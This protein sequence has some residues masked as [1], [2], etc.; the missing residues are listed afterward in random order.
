M[1]IPEKVK[2]EAKGPNVLDISSDSDQEMAVADA[3]PS[4]NV[5]N[6][7]SAIDSDSNDEVVR[8]IPVFLS[9][10]LA[11]QMQLIQY[12]LQQRAHPAAPE[13]V[14]VK[15]RHC[16]MEQ[17]H[18]TPDNIGFNGLYHMPS[19]TFSSH[20]IPV[21]TNMALGKLVGSDSGDGASLHLVP[22]SRI[23]QMR[24]SFS[25]I[26]EAM[27]ASTATTEEELRRQEQKTA[28]PL[29]GR[30]SIGFQKKESERQEMARKSSYGYKKASEDAE[31]WHSLEVYDEASLQA[32]LIL[33]RVACPIE[34]RETYLLDVERLKVESKCTNI[35]GT[36][37]NAKY[38]N[39]LNYLPPRKDFG[40]SGSS[41]PATKTPGG[42]TETSGTDELTLPQIVAKLVPLMRQG[43]PVP[44]SLLRAEFPPETATDDQLFV[45]L[46]SCAVLVRG[47]WCLGSK[48]LGYSPPMTRTRTFLMCLFQTMGVVHKERLLGVFAEDDGDASEGGVTPEVVDFLL[49][50]L[51]EKS[52]AGWVLKVADDA[53]FQKL[54]PQ[55]TMVHLQHWAKQIELFR[56][57]FETYRADFGYDGIDDGGMDE[58]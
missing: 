17:D 41:P 53:K 55:T 24:P 34:H 23:T 7:S 6:Q 57:M 30:K 25:H 1:A 12:P 47:N 33:S 18:K 51:G 36:S 43:Q 19:R 49:E 38:L 52:P 4:S 40:G 45:A 14:R 28:D 10:D 20:T 16:M 44:F 31:G 26:D 3:I 58:S 2:S 9:P 11:H 42:D 39:T 35:Q 21:T 29:T 48:F 56:P 27:A 50:Q 22:L 13:A 37:P 46:G 5:A 54:H 15:P 32:N 8:E